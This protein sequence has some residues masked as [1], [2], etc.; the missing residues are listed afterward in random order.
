MVFPLPG[1]KQPLSPRGVGGLCGLRRAGAQPGCGVG[2]SPAVEVTA[3]RKGREESWGGDVR[4]GRVGWRHG[5]RGWRQ[6]RAQ[7]PGF[8]SLSLLHPE[9]SE[10][11]GPQT[12]AALGVED[13]PCSTLGGERG[14]GAGPAPARCFLVEH[15]WTWAEPSPLARRRGPSS[16]RVPGAH[17][18]PLPG[19]RAGATFLLAPWS[20]MR[21]CVHGVGVG[22]PRCLV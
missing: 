18:V 19:V 7:E 6:R 21:A 9:A 14:A 15:G 13:E 12:E 20:F 10:P 3:S 1:Q 16:P 2:L 5:A 4:C 11:L 8:P 17:G 22:K